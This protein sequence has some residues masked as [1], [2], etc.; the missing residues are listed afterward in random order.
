M[1]KAKIGPAGIEYIQGALLRPKKVDGHNHGNYLIATHRQAATNNPDGC[2]RL[3]TRSA[4]AYKRSTAL[5]TKEVE[6]RNRFTAVQA[7]VKTRATSLAHMTADQEAFEA[8][9]NAADGKRTMRAYLWKIC[10]AEYD[11]EHPQG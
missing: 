8:Q 9:K 1:A 6:I 7:M 2:Q 3:Y 10:G 4:D 5:S 11:A